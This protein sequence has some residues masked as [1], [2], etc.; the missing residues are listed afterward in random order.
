METIVS[1]REFFTSELSNLDCDE[2]T[3]AYIVSILT[4]FK[5]SVGDLSNDSI[6]IRYSCAQSKYSFYEFQNIGDYLFFCNSMYPEHLNGASID[7]YYSLASQSYYS[8]YKILNRSF[9]IY[10][11]L[12]DEFIPL[13]NSTRK[14]IQQL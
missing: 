2:N 4:K 8:C 10:E 14:I 3:R 12:A 5:S 11:Q 9:R 7:Y 1:I 6:T 13:S